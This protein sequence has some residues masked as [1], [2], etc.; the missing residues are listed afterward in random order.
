M[1]I[2]ATTIHLGILLFGVVACFPFFVPISPLSSVT[3]FP[4]TETS[5]P[6]IIWFPSTAT[7]TPLP[8]ATFSI[9][10]TLEIKPEY[11]D[12]ILSDNFI[13]SALWS[14]GQTAAGKIAIGKEELCLAI[15]QP[16]GYLF[17]LREDT[18]IDDFYLEI[19]ANPSICSGE[20]EYG[21]LIRV[22]PSLD[23][24]RFGLT[25]NGEARVDRLLDG[26][27]SS[28]HPPTVSGAVPPGAPSSSR[29]AVWA[30]G[31]DIL[32]YVNGEYLFSVRDTV[33]FG[34]G[35][36]L[37][38]RASGEDAMTVNFSNLTIYQ[39]HK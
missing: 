12:L 37:Y 28:P 34:G 3:P 22:S 32:F 35:L 33:L 19:T 27:A 18:L 16:Q 6:T 36:G 38:V 4:P 26:S 2:V 8:S 1:K 31:P 29:I 39:V 30:L 13:D 7:N 21:M 11:S 23:F 15:N 14:V 9:T 20:D 25:C 24:Y 17:S 5:T 10:P